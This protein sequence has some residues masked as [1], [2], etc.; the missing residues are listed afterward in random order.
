[1][2]RGVIFIIFGNQFFYLPTA[3]GAIFFAWGKYFNY[4]RMNYAP[5]TTLQIEETVCKV[6][7]TRRLMDTHCPFCGIRHP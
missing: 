7:T 5:K 3:V 1:M 2:R 4:Q 6:D